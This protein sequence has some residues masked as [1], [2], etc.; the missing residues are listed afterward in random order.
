M[1]KSNLE[2]TFALFDQKAELRHV[3]MLEQFKEFT[4]RADKHEGDDKITHTNIT[5]KINDLSALSIKMGFIGIVIGYIIKL[6]IS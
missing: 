2:T 1:Q 5:N 3:A 6:V 4:A